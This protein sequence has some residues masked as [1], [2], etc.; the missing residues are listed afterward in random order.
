M[1]LRDLGVV[2]PSHLAHGYASAVGWRQ[3]PVFVPAG[4]STIKG[5]SKPGE[6]VWSPVFIAHGELNLDVGRASVAELPETGI[7]DCDCRL[8]CHNCG[9]GVVCYR[10]AWCGGLGVVARMTRRVGAP[11]ATNPGVTRACYDL[12]EPCP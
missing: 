5:V 7:G 12:T 3:N 2:P 8:S 4:R 10:R 9:S 11:T 1:G 6:I